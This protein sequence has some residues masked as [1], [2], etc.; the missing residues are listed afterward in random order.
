MMVAVSIPKEKFVVDGNIMGY[1]ARFKETFAARHMTG[2]TMCANERRPCTSS[3]D[4]HWITH[5]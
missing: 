1:K 5:T 2:I 4:T 3:E